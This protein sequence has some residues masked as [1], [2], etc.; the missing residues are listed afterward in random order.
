MLEVERRDACLSLFMSVSLSLLG[1]LTMPEW[2]DACLS[3]AP[4]CRGNGP[5]LMSRKQ[6]ARISFLCP[7][8]ARAAPLCLIGLAARAANFISCHTLKRAG[9]SRR[10]QTDG[11]PN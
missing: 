7:G 10:T 2:K 3:L 1:G 11:R 8:R 4:H 5:V 6:R 9:V